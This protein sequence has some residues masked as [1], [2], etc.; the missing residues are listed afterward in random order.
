MSHQVP[1]SSIDSSFDE[2]TSDMIL[3]G[4]TSAQRS[5]RFLIIGTPTLIT[6]IV[7]LLLGGCVKKSTFEALQAKNLAEQQTNA[8]LNAQVQKLQQDGRV[9]TQERDTLKQQ[10][11]AEQKKNTQLV[12]DRSSLQNS[13]EEMEGAPSPSKRHFVENSLW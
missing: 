1:L 5:L 12:S 8:Q 6:L 11:S 3:T 2:F 4:H 13:V 10:L 7:G 9:L